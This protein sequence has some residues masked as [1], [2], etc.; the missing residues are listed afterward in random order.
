[1]STYIV[2]PTEDQEKVFAA[3]LEEQHIS[4]IKDG[5]DAELP[6]HVLEGI[7]RGL[8]DIKA[9]RTKTFEEIKRKYPVE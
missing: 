2:T 5:D 3:F 4:F 9:G 8:E 7:E 6:K 1:M